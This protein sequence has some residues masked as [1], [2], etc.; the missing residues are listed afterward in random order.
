MVVIFGNNLIH[1]FRPAV[2][3]HNNR[4]YQTPVDQAND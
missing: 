1:R 3:G 2:Q 4:A